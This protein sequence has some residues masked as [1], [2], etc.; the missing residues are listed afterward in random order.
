MLH[1]NG[2]EVQADCK[3]L[4]EY[5]NAHGYDPQ[6]LAVER[7]GDIVPKRYYEATVLQDGDSVEIVT[8]VGGG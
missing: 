4:L 3:T 8:F 2:Q 6:R 7:N 1:I 5:L